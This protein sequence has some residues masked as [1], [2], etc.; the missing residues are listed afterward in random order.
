M[1]LNDWSKYID[2]LPALPENVRK[3]YKSVFV[4]LWL[5]RDSPK[6]LDRVK[7]ELENLHAKY[8]TSYNSMIEF[9]NKRVALY[10]DTKKKK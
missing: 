7:N 3:T 1:E 4:K 8:K 10:E 6:E 2:S 9:T 5:F